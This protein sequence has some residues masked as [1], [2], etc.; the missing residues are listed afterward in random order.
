MFIFP[1][2]YFIYLSVPGLSSITSIFLSASRPE[3]T[4][5]FPQFQNHQDFQW[6]VAPLPGYLIPIFPIVRKLNTYSIAYSL[7]AVLL[8]KQP[9][10]QCQDQ[11]H[12]DLDSGLDISFLF[13]FH[14][15]IQCFIYPNGMGNINAVESYTV[16]EKLTKECVYSAQDCEI[17][18]GTSKYCL[19]MPCPQIV[20]G[21]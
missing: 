18:M 1:K 14:V 4:A 16:V 9:R 2:Q 21:S 17:Q 6:V 11:L 13:V 12:E 5:H 7:N 10:A 3:Q 20:I 19:C 15:I 8:Q